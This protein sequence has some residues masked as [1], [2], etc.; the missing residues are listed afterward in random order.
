MGSSYDW[1]SG[2]GGAITGGMAGAS[3]FGPWGAAL[4]AGAGL[5]GG[6]KKTQDVPWGMVVEHPQYSFTEPRMQLTSDFLSQNLN[7][8]N[9]GQQSAYMQAAMPQMRSLMSDPLREQYYGRSGER[10]GVLADTAAM[11]AA[12]GLGPRATAAYTQKALRDYTTKEGAIDQYLTQLGVNV[13][14][15]DA[16][17]FANMS[18]QMPRGP[19]VSVV[20]APAAA[21]Q[22]PQ[23]PDYTGMMSQMAAGYG[24]NGQQQQQGGSQQGAAPYAW[25]GNNQYTPMP[26]NYPGYT[27]AQ[28][29]AYQGTGQQYGPTSAAVAPWDNTAN[30]AVRRP[31]WQY[32]T[33]QSQNPVGDW[34]SSVTGG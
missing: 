29:P 13:Q 17:N 14:Q 31:A 33:N 18:M 6:K 15:Q 22:Q 25:Q 16:Y 19:E 12:T 23:Y 8:L 26:A 11:G 24:Y 28:N 3:M 27:G 30:A 2:A 1:A 4:G 21:Y 34:W 20:G 9:S 7:R 32:Y 10:G 5:L